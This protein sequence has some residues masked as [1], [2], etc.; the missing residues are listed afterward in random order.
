MT[1]HDTTLT[2]SLSGVVLAAVLALAIWALYTGLRLRGRSRI[3]LEKDLRH[4]AL[5]AA[6]PA[7]A[8]IVHGDGR[9]EMPQ[10]VADWLGLDAPPRFL[11]ELSGN[12]AGLLAE[13]GE[14]I[15]R[16]VATTQRS[17]RPFSL[18]VRA[19]GAERALV[20]QGQRAPG[21][22]HAP[23]AV[24]LWFFDATES[25]Q[26]IVRLEADPTTH[27]FEDPA[28][29]AGPVNFARQK[30]A[31][32]DVNFAY[33]HHFDNGD[34]LN[35]GANGTLVLR[36]DNYL[37]V[38]NPDRVSRQLSNLGDPKWEA[39]AN[40]DYKHG[41]VTLHYKLQFIGHMY[42]GDYADYFSL[43]GEDPQEPEYTLQRQYPTVFYHD[44][45]LTFD[46]D[47]KFQFY[48][49]VD[50]LTDKLPPFGQLGTG[51]DAIYDNV[52]RFFYSGFK[53]NI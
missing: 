27:L 5:E 43:N 53:I 11:G 18:S 15:A 49:G 20:V 10:Q 37:D 41:P 24:V 29:L 21:E 38:S 46:V 28:V 1:A 26:E 45:K 30:T 47:K 7:Q 14:A 19:R 34:I 12:D 40:L 51:D 31:G 52:G 3:A 13:D 48:M 9:V 44:L 17:G 50:N 16:E 4:T 33:N 8:V 32:V 39:V 36:R 42:I 2:M 6:S 23:G 35:V 22:G 25:Q